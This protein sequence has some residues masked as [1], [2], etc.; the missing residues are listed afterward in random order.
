MKTYKYIKN[1]MIYDEENG[2]G[3]FGSDG[4]IDGVFEFT[5]E[6]VFIEIFLN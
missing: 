6:H 1:E 2:I 5:R 4:G 3:G